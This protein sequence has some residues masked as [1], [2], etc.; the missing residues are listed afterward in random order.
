MNQ[1][2]EVDKRV[3]WR[4]YMAPWTLEEL[5]RCWGGVEGFKVV[6]KNLME[7]L[8][9]M[10]GGVP[11]YVLEKPMAVLN[12]NPSDTTGAKERAFERVRQAI[13]FVQTPLRMMQCFEQGRESLEH[14][15]RLLHRWPTADHN[16]FR[17]EW[18]ST[19]IAD[20]IDKSVKDV[21]WQQIL[22]KLTGVGV[23]TTKGPMF[24]LYVRHIFRKGG[25]E[26]QIKD[27]QDGSDTAFK[28]PADPSMVLFDEIPAVPPGTL[29]IPKNCTFACVDLLLSPKYLLQVTVS[30]RHDIKGPPFSTLLG[31]LK[32]K[33]WIPSGDVHLVFVVP[34][35]IYDNFPEQK[36]L[37]DKG[38]VYKR[39]P[40]LIGS[41]KQ[42]VLKIDLK[43][44]STGKSPG[45]YKLEESTLEALR[46][47]L[48]AVSLEL[49]NTQLDLM[50]ANDG[51]TS[52]QEEL[53][54]TQ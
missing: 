32:D 11:R 51:L 39:V 27:L 36:Y 46:K 19:Y 10:I 15:S 22:E 53:E 7:E 12:L 8:Y 49:R 1:Y 44:A 5:E 31:N 33:G 29:C 3:P 38:T 52:T 2:Q 42:F 4:Y 18:A 34:S 35:E 23:G 16:N 50:D 24:E 30:K 43:S 40:R 48:A 28:V 17:L 14:S 13:D 47:K 6:P 20:E 54:D 26:F 21:T 41:V 9:G 45:I 37:S 25:Y